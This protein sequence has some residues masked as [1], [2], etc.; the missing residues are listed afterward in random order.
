MIRKAAENEFTE[1]N[2]PTMDAFLK[3]CFEK[4]LVVVKK[5][6]QNYNSDL[7][8]ALKELLKLDKDG[9]LHRDP[10]DTDDSFNKAQIA[11]D[12]AMLPN[13]SSISEP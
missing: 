8:S 9:Y 12:T 5:V 13:Q 11:I 3:E 2:A 6:E 4:T 1:D 10:L 7:L